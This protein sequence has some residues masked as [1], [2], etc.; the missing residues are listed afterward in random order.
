MKDRS[1][2]W[3]AVIVATGI[4]LRMAPLMVN[5]NHPAIFM[6]D[7][8]YGYH[9]I[10]VNLLA[11]H[12]YSWSEQPPY[13][14]NVYRPPGLPLL[15]A[16]VYAVAGVAVPHMILVQAVLAGLTIVLL[17]PLARVV[18]ADART[19]LTAAAVLAVDPVSIYYSNFLL[20]ETYTALVVVA[21]MV[22]VVGYSR[23]GQSRYLL[24]IGALLAA[25]VMIH[26][27]LLFA[28]FGLLALPLVTRGARNL[29]QFGL[30]GLAVLI[31]LAPAAAWVV[32]NKVAA[33][34]AG[35]SCVTA[36]NLLKY[37]AASVEAE[38][39]GTTRE[40]ER[41]RLTQLCEESLP[42]GAGNGERW[43][44]W[45]RQAAA[46]LLAHPGVYAKVHVRGAALE[47]FG[48]ERDHF[49]RFTCGPAVIDP[50]SGRV[51]DDCIHAAVSDQPSVLREGMRL[52]VLA[53]QAAIMLMLFLGTVCLVARR[54]WLLLGA[55]LLPAAYVLLL[56]GGS[57]ASP[58]FRV[59]YTPLL[60]LMAG[61]GLQACLSRLRAVRKWTAFEPSRARGAA[62]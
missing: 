62:E 47:F 52:V 24:A 13:E 50:V 15:L 39:R 31:A 12:G 42:P 38:L 61:V 25:G 40:I 2:R 35:V 48:P 54:Q 44:T 33:D 20:T 26:P 7:D 57:E 41:D 1:L 10:A 37:K 16:A 60:C 45:E 23:T 6:D 27:I 22:L 34:Y 30:A 19:A 58:R 46:I 8:S 43:R 36:V 59:I 4:L 28:P 53:L 18:G 55:L 51:A 56:S 14:P 49:S 21:A 3:L 17:Y 9:Q 11:G 29:R 32:R 5:W